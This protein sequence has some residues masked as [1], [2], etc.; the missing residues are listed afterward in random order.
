MTTQYER[1]EGELD[2]LKHLR[3]EENRRYHQEF[4]KLNIELTALRVVEVT[5]LRNIDELKENL[6]L[7]SAER[8]EIR[9]QH[10]CDCQSM[11]NIQ[12]ILS[13]ETESNSKSAAK[14][15]L[16]SRQLEDE[17]KRL[18]AVR[19]ELNDVQ[20]QL[21][22]ASLT[23]ETLNAELSQS[24]SLSQDYLDKVRLSSAQDK[25]HFFLHVGSRDEAASQS[26]EERS[27]RTK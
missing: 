5:L 24:R 23:I 15:L 11:Q 21:S 10:Q 7:V 13:D 9:Q 17:Q 27:R 6:S 16:L 26:S 3:D 14:V 22:T 1:I 19:Y 8:N 4:D 25:P 18:T 2:Q 20:M 12:Q